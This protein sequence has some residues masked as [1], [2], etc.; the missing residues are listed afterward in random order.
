VGLV[1]HEQGHQAGSQQ[2]QK[3]FVLHALGREI[4]ELEPL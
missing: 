1:H 4:D 3:P 2:A